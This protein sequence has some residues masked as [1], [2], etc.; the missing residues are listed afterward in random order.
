M[1]LDHNVARRRERTLCL[2]ILL[3]GT[4]LK[5]IYALQV[6]CYVSPHDLD[7]LSD[8]VQRT[9][10]HLGYIQYLYQYRHLLQTSPVGA[11]Q[12][13]HPP[14]FYLVGAAVMQLFYTMGDPIEP[15]F[16]LL[17]LV[18]TL[19]ACGIAFVGWRILTHL[20]VTG[21][22]L[23]VLTA[24]L[25]FGP[26]L[27]WL[28]TELNNDCLMTLLQAMTIEQTILWAKKPRTGVI[29]KMALLLAL[30]MLTKTSA[31]LIAPAIGCVFLYELIRR[32]RQKDGVWPL[33]GQFALFAVISIPLGTSYVLRNWFLFQVPPNYVPNM[34]PNDP[35]YVGSCSVLRRLGLPSI[36]QLF[37]ARIHWEEPANFCNI[38]WQTALTM[39]LDEGI[40]VLRNTAQKV[41]A[42]LLIWSCAGS[43]LVLLAGTVRALLSKKASIPVR[44][45]LGVGFCAVFGS[46]VLFCFQYP[47]L[48]TMNFRYIYN[49]LI[50]LAAG[51]G[52]RE[53]E[54]SIGSRA[55]VWTHCLLSTGLYLLCAVA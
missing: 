49:T 50:F 23:V 8:W 31:V 22:K 53:G 19:F 13:Y 46:Y 10:G 12:F 16:E 52:I 17:Q 25:S 29:I 2:L 40:L 27:Y 42:V 34:G 38:W 45:L 11:G 35:Q 32:I 44:L 51:Y 55:L 3:A 20:E 6:S 54:M 47:H 21:K 39:A 4:M 9:N 30:A 7:R 14:L 48:C 36:R 26:T 37:S 28:G 18:N 15:V 5:L 41:C 1:T 43:I 33:I 24:F